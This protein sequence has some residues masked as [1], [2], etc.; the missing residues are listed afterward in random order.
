MSTDQK[1]A[2]PTGTDCSSDEEETAELT[3]E[4]RVRAHLAFR[5]ARTTP[6]NGTIIQLLSKNYL[7]HLIHHEVAEE[8]WKLALARIIKDRL[9]S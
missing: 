8:A 5:H 7:D 9:K 2:D 6:Y 1:R 3:P 4:E